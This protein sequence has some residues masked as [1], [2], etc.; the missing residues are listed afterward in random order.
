MSEDED[1]LELNHDSNDS[2]FEPHKRIDIPV[3]PSKIFMSKNGEMQ[4]SSSQ[5]MHRAKGQEACF[6]EVDGAGQNT[7]R[8]LFGAPH[9]GW[10]L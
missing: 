3:P 2:D 6:C 9:P 10:A 5:N 1:H 7:F 4:W 8:C